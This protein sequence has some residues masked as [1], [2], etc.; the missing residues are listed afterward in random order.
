M[1]LS[2]RSSKPRRPWQ[3]LEQPPQRVV[4]QD[5]DGLLRDGRRLESPHGV[6]NAFLFLEPAIEAVQGAE[7][8]V[9]RRGSPSLQ[10]GDEVVM[11]VGCAGIGKATAANVEER[12]E[13]LEGLEIG[14]DGALGPALGPH[15]PFEGTDKWV[16]PGSGHGR[17]VA[18]SLC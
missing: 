3:G 10:D 13:L 8:V 11:D 12:R 1:A 15:E 17:K 2:R 7:P 6:G 5:R 18:G 9:G 4:V 14:V 16:Y